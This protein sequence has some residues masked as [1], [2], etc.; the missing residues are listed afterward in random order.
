MVSVDRRAQRTDGAVVDA[1]EPRVMLTDDVPRLRRE[2]TG[3]G[4][5]VAIAPH[6]RSTRHHRVSAADRCSPQHTQTTR[7]SA[8]A[9]RLR[10]AL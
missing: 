6:P 10:T 1:A 9:E 7:S 5:L 8:I 3:N 2:V 4:R